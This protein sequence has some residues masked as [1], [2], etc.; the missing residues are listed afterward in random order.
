M[1]KDADKPHCAAWENNT[2]FNFVVR[3]LSN[4]SRDAVLPLFAV[5]RVNALQPL[6]PCRHAVVRIETVDSVPLVGYMHELTSRYGPHPAS[7]MSESLDLGEMTLTSRQ[8]LLSTPVR[9][10]F[11]GFSQRSANR[12]Y[13]PRKSRLQN[14]IRGSDF[15]SFNR[16]FFADGSGNKDE[17]NL[18]TGTDR[19]SQCRE[20][21]KRGK[22]I[23]RENQ[24]NAV[25]NRILKGR[26]SIHSQQITSNVGGLKR[27]LNEP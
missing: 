3:L 16:N 25:C 1:P 18:R 21:I 10:T 4:G 23:V 24:V 11:F 8:S 13:Q 26:L 17:R 20:A 7:C 12:R 22:G 14:I 19:E 27:V 9:R 5:L 6:F 2:G 15:Q